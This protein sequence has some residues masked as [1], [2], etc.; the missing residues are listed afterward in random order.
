M[1]GRMLLFGSVA[2]C[3][4]AAWADATRNGGATGVEDAAENVEDPAKSPSHAG[5]NP[6]SKMSDEELGSVA[7]TY[8]DLDR[9][10]RRWFLIEISKRMPTRGERPKIPIQEV[11]RF[12]RVIQEASGPAREVGGLD[13]RRPE[14]PGDDSVYGQGLDPRD[15]RRG[16]ARS[17]SVP[18]VPREPRQIEGSLPRPQD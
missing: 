17:P 16:D 8:E 9:D 4:I 6:Y 10:E 12:G 2:T 5:R 14:S 18:S 11:G 13:N 15:A 3:S 7:A 1:V